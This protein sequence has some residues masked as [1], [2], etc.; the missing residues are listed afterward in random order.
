MYRGPSGPPRYA[1]PA[2]A[3]RFSPPTRLRDSRTGVRTCGTR[4]SSGSSACASPCPGAAPADPRRAGHTCRPAPMGHRAASSAATQWTVGCVPRMR[5]DLL[6]EGFA[7]SKAVRVPPES[8]VVDPVRPSERCRAQRSQSS[9]VAAPIIMV[10]VLR[11]EPL[12]R[13][14]LAVARAPSH[15]LHAVDQPRGAGP[16]RE[17]EG[18]LQERAIDLLAPARPLSRRRARRVSPGRPTSLS[19]GHRSAGSTGD[20]RPGPL[21]PVTCMSPPMPCADQVEPRPCSGRARRA[22]NRSAARRSAGGSPR[23]APRISRPARLHYGRAG[24]SRRARSTLRTS[25]RNT[26]RPGPLVVE[27]HALLVPG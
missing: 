16:P 21:S 8:R 3:R 18:G 11:R 10:A 26:A 4:P 24:S 14:V 23:P 19:P 6:L 12:V 2:S 17:A 9:W 27:R 5:L 20:G 15:G 7:M 1:R 22:R 25:R 13:R